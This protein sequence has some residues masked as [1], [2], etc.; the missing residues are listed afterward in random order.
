LYL[1]SWLLYLFVFTSK[2]MNNRIILHI[3]MNSYFASVEQQANPFLRGKP[4]G[5]CAYLSPRGVIIASSMEAKKKGI[6]TGTV[7]RE[8]KKLDPDVVLVE[9]EP[10]KYRSTTE[11][12]F[13]IFTDYTERVEPYSIDEAFLDLTGWVNNFERATQLGYEIQHRIKNEVGEWLNASVGVSWT[14]WL[15]KFAGDIAPKKSVLTIE[16]KKVLDYHLGKQSL[17][18][19]WGINYRM[20]R[21]LNMLGIKT[22]MDLKN[23]S[24]S[25]IRHSLG[26]YGYYLWSHV[27]GKEITEVSRGVKEAKSIGHSYCIPKKTKDKEYLSCVLYKLCEKTGRRLRGQDREAQRINVFLAYTRGGGTGR[28]FTTPDK[29][30]TTEEIYASANN[31][32]EKTK[33]LMSIRMVAVSVGRLTPVT[34]QMSMFEDN[35]GIKDLSRALDKINN[36]YGE[37]TVVRG[38]MFGTDNIA[39]DRIGFRKTINVG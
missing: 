17:L 34:S 31:F 39:R 21:R 22:L 14:K 28:S 36:K 11:K 32:L 8:A 38:Q 27:N 26:R 9:N 3:D 7:V 23:F 16:N 18:D 25:K 30:F 6:K 4:V 2:I 15:A 13:K 10:A 19:A 1:V 29:L 35:L 20:E 5:V 37:Y 12:I 33:L 24:A